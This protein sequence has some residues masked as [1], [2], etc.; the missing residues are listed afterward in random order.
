MKKYL[1]ALALVGAVLLSG[2]G[3]HM[4]LTTNANLTATTVELS[5][6]NF[7]VVKTV[8]GEAEAQYILGFGGLKK[9]ALIELAKKDMIENAGLEGS[10]RALINVT[11]EEYYRNYVVLFR[12]KVVV[13]AQVVEFE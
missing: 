1:I 4:P 6:D 11:V 7:T 13:T 5:E 9:R 10:S 3:I 8:S 12:R 2:C